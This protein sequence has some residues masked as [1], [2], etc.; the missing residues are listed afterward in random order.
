MPPQESSDEHAT[1][2]VSP[3]RLAAHLVSAFTIYATLVWT[4]LDLM[5]PTPL[6]A[7][8]SSVVAKASKLATSRLLPLAVFVAITATSGAFVAGGRICGFVESRLRAGL[9]V[10]RASMPQTLDDGPCVLSLTCWAC[11]RCKGGSTLS[12]NVKEA[13]GVASISQSR[14]LSASVLHRP[15]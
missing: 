8:A 10:E 14:H 13:L 12:T 7:G 5:Q 1:P 2:R 4:T 6:T 3:Y 11:Y 15:S 9:W